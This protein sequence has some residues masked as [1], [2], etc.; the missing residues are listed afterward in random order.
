[1]KAEYVLPYPSAMPGNK[2]YTLGKILDEIKEHWSFGNIAKERYYR[3]RADKHLVQA[4]VL[5]EYKQYVLASQALEESNNQFA[6][7]SQYLMDAY[8]EGKDTSKELET[9]A[10]AAHKHIEVLVNTKSALP[11]S[12]EWIP[13]K[14]DATNLMIG[15]RIMSSIELRQKSVDTMRLFMYCVMSMSADIPQSKK[16]TACKE[17]YTSFSLPMNVWDS[18]ESTNREQSGSVP[19]IETKETAL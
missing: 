19:S 1:V 18:I 5:F 14:E 10:D 4:K 8:G 3:T 15:D 2:L 6:K 9:F 13:E 16:A 12:F 7:I 17:A 11:N